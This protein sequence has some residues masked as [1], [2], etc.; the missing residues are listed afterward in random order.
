MKLQKNTIIL[1]LLAFGLGSYVL[2]TEE[3]ATAPVDSATEAS[4]PLRT[5]IFSAP[6]TELAELEIE[7]PGQQTPVRIVRIDEDRA[8]SAWKM[9]APE[10]GTVAA[11]AIAFLTE[12]LLVEVSEGLRAFA[13]EPDLLD[14][15]GLE[16]PL[17]TL[18]LTWTGDRQQQLALGNPSFDGRHLYAQLDPAREQTPGEENV[19]ILLVDLDLQYA[20]ERPLDEWLAP[21][22]EQ[23]TEDPSE[24]ESGESQ[25]VGSDASEGVGPSGDTSQ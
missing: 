13:V 21:P 5:T 19:E 17:A 1:F 8:E 15:Y 9:V 20:V 25:A 22:P 2:V 7:R 11:S 6:N 3:R 23:E 14:E 12:V 24:A 18:T 4:E 16:E 10:T